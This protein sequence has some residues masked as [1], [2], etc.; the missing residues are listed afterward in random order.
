MD[1]AASRETILIV[2]DVKTSFLL[3]VYLEREGFK[4]IA[5]HDGRHA[6]ELFKQRHPAFTILDP[7]LPGV[8]GWEMCQE[9]K[10]LS[11][12]PIL[13]LTAQGEAH[14]SVMWLTLGA[15]DYVTKPCDLGEL[16]ARVKAILRRARPN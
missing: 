4:T 15:D 16:V 5:A 11:D 7:S 10:R 12:A 3:S 9:L 13:I 8:D 6:L 1:Q 14:E 2:E